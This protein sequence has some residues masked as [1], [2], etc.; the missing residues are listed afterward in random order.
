MRAPPPPS[1]PVEFN[2]FRSGCVRAHLFSLAVSALC[3]FERCQSEYSRSAQRLTLACFNIGVEILCF[4]SPALR[5]QTDSTPPPDTDWPPLR[6]RVQSTLIA[7]MG[8]KSWFR[9]ISLGHTDGLIFFQGEFDNQLECN[10][11]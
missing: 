6:E 9:A 5:A 7:A 3:T 4:S 1:D 8:V 11:L 2:P 10:L